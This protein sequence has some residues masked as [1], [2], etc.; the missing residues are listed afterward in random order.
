MQIKIVKHS[1]SIINIYN[2]YILQLYHLLFTIMKFN[3]MVIVQNCSDIHMIPDI[4]LLF[5]LYAIVHKHER[6]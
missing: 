1:D 3:L 4:N 5:I 6:C 2:I